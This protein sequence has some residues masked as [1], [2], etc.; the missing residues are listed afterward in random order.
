MPRRISPAAKAP[1]EYPGSTI[2]I[3]EDLRPEE[4]LRFFQLGLQTVVQRFVGLGL[5]RL[6]MLY[7]II[8]SDIARR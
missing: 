7:W 3:L 4:I 1:K 8:F 2:R 6:R 5:Q